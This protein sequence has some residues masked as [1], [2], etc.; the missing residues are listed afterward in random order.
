VWPVSAD[1]PVSVVIDLT[2]QDSSGIAGLVAQCLAQSLY[3]NCEI[4]I[5]N[6]SGT[7]IEPLGF[8]D[9]VKVIDFLPETTNGK[10]YQSAVEK[11][12][13]E[14]LVFLSADLISPDLGQT[15][16]ELVGWTRYEEIGVV[17][18]MLLA[19]DGTVTSTGLIL[20]SDGQVAAFGKGLAPF[21]STVTGHLV[22]YRN[23][24]AIPYQCMAVRKEVVKK[25]NGFDE[26]LDAGFHIDFCLRLSGE[27]LRHFYTPHAVLQFQQKSVSDV[28]IALSTQ[29][30]D[31]LKRSHDS[32]FQHTD[33]YFNPH[34]IY[35]NERLSL[36][37]NQEAEVVPRANEVKKPS[38][39]PGTWDVYSQ[40]AGFLSTCLD[41]DHKAL[42]KN[43]KLIHTNSGPIAIKSITWFLP[44]FQNAF[45]GGVHTIL[46]F[47]A[48]L[49]DRHG[50][51]NRFVIVG[52]AKRSHIQ[53]LI[54]MAFPTLSKAEVTVITTL[55]SVG[56]LPATDAAI[57]TLWTT[58]YYQM[59]FNQTRR[60]FYFIQDYEPAFYPAGSTSGQVETTYR[61]GYYGITNTISLKTI[62]ERDY[63]GQG[64]YFTPST[65]SEVFYPP[66]NQR[67]EKGPRRVFFYVRPG[68]PRNA[69]E[70]GMAALRILK[71][72]M[73]DGIEIV[74][75]GSDW[76]PED[77][78]LQ[79]IITNYGLLKYEETGNLYR[80]C[81]SGMAM[82]FTRHPSYI[83]FELMAC[84]SLVVTNYNSATDWL[85]KNKEN[86][87]LSEASATAIAE[88]VERG[89]LDV[90]LRQQ[91]TEKAYRLI[92]EN[93]YDWSS[94]IEKIYR[95]MCA[96]K[97]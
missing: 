54:E 26:N 48:Y 25:V 94:Q 96:P 91:I 83:P 38:T 80:S 30:I 18:G 17:G 88:T 39:P 29:E 1:L 42:Q 85:F 12:A 76:N 52:N 2:N 79:G 68:H 37:V 61:F 36:R 50:V 45:Y 74:T 16:H 19:P 23:F 34:L 97:P 14:V 73:Q 92:Q 78:N 22:W 35:R 40:E 44:E 10:A 24:S 75:A 5:L 49:K 89:L 82:M 51:R 47:A 59:Q 20:N 58:A 71:A 81:H 7:R 53:K 69:F 66:K 6:R 70:L 33:P 9:N 43:K 64:E 86:C 4:I 46:R 27:K 72:N 21:D 93:H 77:Y 57:C 87:L 62:Y 11:A 56:S 90:E 8:G 60:K 32:F 55:D 31:Y 13:G 3:A 65:N 41:V 95:Y 28:N 15:V 67:S 84:K 63:D